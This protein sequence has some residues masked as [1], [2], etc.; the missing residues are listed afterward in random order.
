LALEQ[1]FTIETSVVHFQR[2]QF[3]FGPRRLC[4]KALNAAERICR[5]TRLMLTP[6]IP[7]CGTKPNDPKAWERCYLSQVCPASRDLSPVSQAV[8]QL[9]FARESLLETGC[10]SGV[11]SAELAAAGRRI[12]LCDFSQPI[13]DQAA[14]LFELS[15]LATPRLT[16]ADLTKPL[17]WR[18]GAVDVVWSSGVLEHWTDDELQPIVREMARISRRAVI[19]LVPYAGCVFYRLGK[20]LAEQERVWPYG[21]ELPRSSQRSVFEQAG[22][23]DIKEYTV[24]ADWSPRMLGITDPQFGGIVNRWWTSLAENDPVKS[25]Q[26]YLL[27][28][29]GYH[30]SGDSTKSPAITGGGK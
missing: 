5:I 23:C 1:K 3:M 15:G 8:A 22:L 17:P 20:Y 11:L 13:L 14:H 28:T 21:R 10:G 16:L 24:W 27:L 12:E 26:G 9:T 19:S 7:E 29:I 25:N 4:L 30:A 2:K 18:D 6:K